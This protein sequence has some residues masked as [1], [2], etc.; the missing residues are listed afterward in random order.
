[1]GFTSL[2]LSDLGEVLDEVA[3]GDLV[4]DS[5]NG[6]VLADSGDSIVAGSTH[7]LDVV[8]LCFVDSVEFCNV[9]LSSADI[10]DELGLGIL[11]SLIN[12]SINLLLGL[13]VDSIE[14]LLLSDGV[15]KFEAAV[16]ALN[17]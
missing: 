2:L 17:A 6:G 8:T 11:V 3:L 4:E 16:A 15:V 10:G 13:V 1:M 9:D 14:S 12:L 5:D 7:I